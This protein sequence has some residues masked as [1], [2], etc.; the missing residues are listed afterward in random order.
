MMLITVFGNKLNKRSFFFILGWG[1]SYIHGR[2]QT[3]EH[4][5][6]TLLKITALRTYFNYSAYVLHKTT[7]A[8]T[9]TTLNY[10]QNHMTHATH[11]M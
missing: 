11:T 3:R 2:S 1:K 7:N 8:T 4:D 6:F 10:K 5:T 9:Q